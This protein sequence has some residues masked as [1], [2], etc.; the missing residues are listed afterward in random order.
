MII[1]TARYILSLVLSVFTDKPVRFYVN[2]VQIYVYIFKYANIIVVVI[3][4]S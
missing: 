2:H 1:M 3:F 4:L